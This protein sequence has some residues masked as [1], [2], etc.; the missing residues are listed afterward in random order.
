M[1]AAEKAGDRDDYADIGIDAAGVAGPGVV[2]GKEHDAPH[3]LKKVVTR[4]S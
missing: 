4:K 3:L 2:A 1:L